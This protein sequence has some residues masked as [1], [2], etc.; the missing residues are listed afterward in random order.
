MDNPKLDDNW[1]PSPTVRSAKAI[2]WMEISRGDD[3]I[4]FHCWVPSRSFNIIPL[5]V[6]SGKIK[7]A[8]IHG[9]KL[10]W[11]KGEVLGIRL[12]ENREEE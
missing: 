12:L 3:T 7:F 2:G 6:K 1:Q 4:T 8:S 5:A 9:T 11:R 10:K